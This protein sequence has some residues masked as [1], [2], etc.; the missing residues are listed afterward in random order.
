MGARDIDAFYIGKTEVT[1]N[2]WQTVSNW[3]AVNGY[4]IGNTGAGDGPNRPVFSV[5]WYQVLKWCNARSEK[6]GLNPVYRVNTEIYRTGNLIPT[7]DMA[8][9]GH[10]LPNEKEWEFAAR[11]G[12]QTNDYE[13]SGSNNVDAV[14]WYNKNS[15]G[16][17]QDVAKK[18]PN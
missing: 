1:W 15:A 9:N 4:D 11:G 6:E 16:S 18:Q 13:Y 8:S 17:T 12:A 10:R 5:N 7:P 14:A 3:A 2:E